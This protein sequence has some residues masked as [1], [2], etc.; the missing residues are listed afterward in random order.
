MDTIIAVARWRWVAIVCGG[1]YGSV[2]TFSCPLLDGLQGYI[3][4]A[5]IDGTIQMKSYLSGSPEIRL[6][7][8]EDLGIGPNGTAGFGGCQVPHH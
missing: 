1:V 3:L 2:L 6:A 7:L 5:E 8:N 4:T